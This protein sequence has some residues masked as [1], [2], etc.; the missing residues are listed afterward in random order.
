MAMDC[1]KDV[2]RYS[3]SVM[4]LSFMTLFEFLN[5]SWIVNS[6]TKSPLQWWFTILVI[7]INVNAEKVIKPVDDIFLSTNVNF[8]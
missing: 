3:L 5:L 8:Q 7:I 1:K 6:V 2:Q 4:S